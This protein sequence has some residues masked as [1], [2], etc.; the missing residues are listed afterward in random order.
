MPVSKIPVIIIVPECFFH[1]PPS[2]FIEM[3]GIFNFFIHG[4]IKRVDIP[5]VVNIIYLLFLR[6][7]FLTSLINPANAARFAFRRF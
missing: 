4:S 1:I 6:V 2:F 5:F 3:K 7:V